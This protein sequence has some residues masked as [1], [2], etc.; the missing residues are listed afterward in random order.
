MVNVPTIFVCIFDGKIILHS[1]VHFPASY[2]SL[3]WMSHVFWV[4][5][6]LWPIFGSPLYPQLCFWWMYLF[7][8]VFSGWKLKTVETTIYRIQPQKKLPSGKLRWQSNISVFNRKII[9]EGSILYCY[10]SLPECTCF[11]VLHTLKLTNH[12]WKSM[13]GRWI[14]FWG[15]A[16][17]QAGHVSF[18]EGERFG[19]WSFSCCSPVL[20][21]IFQEYGT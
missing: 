8:Y 3:R 7:W 11:L 17:F 10:V 5:H 12:P 2:V 14:S 13:V 6:K 4:L 16:Y 1:G 19:R 21:E 15:P 9:F 18:R 20:Q